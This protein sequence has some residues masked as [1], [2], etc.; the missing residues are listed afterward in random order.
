M[1]DEIGGIGNERDFGKGVRSADGRCIYRI[2]IG[3]FCA[4]WTTDNMMKRLRIRPVTIVAT[5]ISTVSLA[6]G[7]SSPRLAVSSVSQRAVLSK[8]DLGR[9]RS[10]AAGGGDV[11]CA[12]R[13]GF[14][15]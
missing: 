5:I 12:C 13:R 9:P 7:L 1:E 6:P 8:R 10:G 3:T 11:G 4:M 2:C 14:G 15:P